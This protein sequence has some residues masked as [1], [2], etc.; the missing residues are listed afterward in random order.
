MI[1][2][3]LKTALENEEELY[4]T[5]SQSYI[6]K[7]MKEKLPYN[8]K[9]TNFVPIPLNGT[10]IDNVM[11]VRGR[12]NRAV[13]VS[14]KNFLQTI[15]LN[16]VSEELTDALEVPNMSFFESMIRKYL[17]IRNHN[18]RQIYET[19][20]RKLRNPYFS[21][22]I[23]FASSFFS[24]KFIIHSLK[25]KHKNLVINQLSSLPYL[26]EELKDK[27]TKDII[28]NLLKIKP[29]KVSASYDSS[30]ENTIKAKGRMNYRRRIMAIDFYF[31][32]EIAVGRFIIP[33][34]LKRVKLTSEDIEEM[35][36]HLRE[37]L[38]TE[39]ETTT[40][41]PEELK[42]FFRINQPFLQ[43]GNFITSFSGI[44]FEGL[45]V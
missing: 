19:E 5:L 23:S 14:N 17:E 44:A 36:T 1:I 33:A 32:K 13:I 28:K 16:P 37:N 41:L 27:I 2:N 7:N 21:Y 6:N 9:F 8:I 29:T 11:Y 35:V 26:N 4:E 39:I 18:E 40:I 15:F 20:F 38:L 34:M 45:P 31:R 25:Q 10:F 3:K 22:L 24:R 43:E 30:E 12:F 42:A